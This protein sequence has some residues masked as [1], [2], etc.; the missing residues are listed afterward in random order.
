MAMAHSNREI[1]SAVLLKWGQPAI[2]SIAGG[3]LMQLPFL[4][5]LEAKIK[6]TGWVSPM[7]SMSKEL[8]P[9]MGGISSQVITPLLANYLKDIPDEAI[10]R[11]AHSIV[12][13][14]IKNGGISLMEGNVVF[15]EEDMVELQ[16]LLRYN[17]PVTESEEYQVKLNE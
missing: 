14:A 16:K 17:L 8:A 3:K 5:N 6:A 1:L 13:N 2:E 12:E 15:E 10:P 7:W 9:L 11:M 4:A